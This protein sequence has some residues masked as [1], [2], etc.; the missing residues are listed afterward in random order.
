[1][2][3]LTVMV[4]ILAAC[5][6]P[7]EKMVNMPDAGVD[8]DAPD[9]ADASDA[10]VTDG[11]AI[12]APDASQAACEVTGDGTFAAQCCPF[13]S[14][15][16]AGL[17]CYFDWTSDPT[18]DP[19]N[20]QCIP[21]TSSAP[22][23]GAACPKGSNYDCADGLFCDDPMNGGHCRALCDVDHACPSGERCHGMPICGGGSCAEANSSS[24]IGY[25]AP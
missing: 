20:S 2:R 19:S 13:S 5:S 16:G 15:C 12:D 18:P 4:A 23:L 17:H 24:Q 1:M 22:G 9:V 6:S 21:E 14:N 3:S 25:C 7:S 8:P 11:S 10:L